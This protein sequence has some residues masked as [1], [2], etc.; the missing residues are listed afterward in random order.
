MTSL[1]EGTRHVWASKSRST[2]HD[3]GA[4]LSCWQV[5]QTGQVSRLADPRSDGTLRSSVYGM[6]ARRAVVII[7]SSGYSSA[8]DYGN[9]AR[10]PRSKLCLAKPII[11]WH[12][13]IDDEVTTT[14]KQRQQACNQT[15]HT[16]F[17]Y[18]PGLCSALCSQQ[19]STDAPVADQECPCPP[20]TVRLGLVRDE[21]P[22]LLQES[23]PQG[24]KQ[25][26][27]GEGR[28]GGKGDA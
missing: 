15:K 13:C 5:R 1:K 2:G 21:W 7:S 18:F 11:R 10:A 9:S 12:C 6:C 23:R 28:G 4:T 19:A 20:C 24:V 16:L 25:N 8:C 22:T 26:Q 14:G 27:W 17:P 3:A